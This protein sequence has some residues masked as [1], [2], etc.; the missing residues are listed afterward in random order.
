MEI[1]D[2]GDTGFSWASDR[3]SWQ[4]R[5]SH[6]L[7]ADGEVW[8]V[9]VTDFPGL[10]EAIHARGRPRAVIQLL[11][12]H[13]RDCASVAARLGVP[14]LENPAELPGTPFRPV[15]VQA[16][17]GWRETALW[18]PERST[19]VV[20]E[21]LGTA[22]YYCAP[23]RKLGVHPFLRFVRL[24]KGLT[25]LEPAHLLVGHG[26]ILDDDV[27]EQIR[28]AVRRARWELPLVIPR[29]VTAHRGPRPAP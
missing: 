24:P 19:L 21:A 20:A 26:P 2:R 16:R 1:T 25:E 4:Q 23:G 14:L 11:D 27:P 7:V 17:R 22:R 13:R 6:A 29:L 8:I 5:M 12:R 3:E 15:V 18:W 10:D 9:D 28:Q